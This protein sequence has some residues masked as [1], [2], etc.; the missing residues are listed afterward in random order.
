MFYDTWESTLGQIIAAADEEGLRHVNFQNGTK[1]LSIPENWK[2]D[3]S[4]LKPVFD[5]L[6]AYFSGELKVFDL[7]LAPSGTPF[8]KTVWNIL[9]TI[10]YGTVTAYSDIAKEMGNPNACRAV[11]MA[12][13][14]NP[15]PIIIPCHRVTGK[16]GRLT[17]YAGGLNFK[18]GLL[19]L[20]GIDKILY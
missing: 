4:Q 19:R 3:S 13:G 16:N 17:G 6:K 9:M 7:L 1:P 20:E 10:P 14:K 8:M 11:G 5:Q 2:R 12:N 15:I 18:E